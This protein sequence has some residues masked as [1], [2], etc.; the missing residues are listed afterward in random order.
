METEENLSD[1]SLI[2]DDEEED[3][4]IDFPEEESETLIMDQAE[5][6]DPQDHED[7]EFHGFT[8]A[9]VQDKPE[10]ANVSSDEDFDITKPFLNDMKDCSGYYAGSKPSYVVRFAES[11][12]VSTG[13]H[14]ES[15]TK[16]VKPLKIKKPATISTPSPML[17]RESREW[18]PSSQFFKPLSAGLDFEIFSNSKFF[19]SNWFGH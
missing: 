7:P 9:D 10:V 18:K 8:D 12:L 16:K 2:E 11:P 17:Q 13:G 6:E 19:T 1:A 3:E 15:M 14:D 5:P 4:I